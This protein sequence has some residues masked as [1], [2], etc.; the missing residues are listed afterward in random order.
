MRTILR[1]KKVKLFFEG[2][3]RWTGD[4]HKALNFKSIDRALTFIRQWQLKDVE[5]AFC[6]QDRDEV[7]AVP[8]DRISLKFSES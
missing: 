5:V 4:P 2:P 8:L 7:M 3:D 1:K 6:F